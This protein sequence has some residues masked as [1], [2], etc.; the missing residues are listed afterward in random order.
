MSFPFFVT[1]IRLANPLRV[2]I[3]GT[4]DRLFGRRRGRVTGRRS[5]SRSTPLAAWRK[6]HEQVLALEQWLPLD[7]G[8][9][10]CV[11]RHPVED[12]STDV[13]VDHLAAP[14]HDRH[15]HLLACFEE[16]LQTFELGLEIVL[17]HLRPQLHLFELD[18]V[19]LAPL[20]LLPLDRLEL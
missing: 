15:F 20:V 19:L 16:L 1:R 10:P 9:W 17:G 6:D 8:K 12:P 13:L 3:L 4:G 18:D 2:L 5:W 7:H 14:E 11:V